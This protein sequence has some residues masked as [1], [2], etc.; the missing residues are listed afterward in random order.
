MYIYNERRSLQAAFFLIMKRRAEARLFMHV[1]NAL[2]LRKAGFVHAANRAGPVVGK[3][4]ECGTGGDAVV[5]IADLGI[6]RVT[7]H[8]AS[9]FFHILYYLVVLPPPSPPK[10]GGQGGWDYYFSGQ[11]AFMLQIRSTTLLE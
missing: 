6:V 10:G 7:A 9:V 2:F 4:L 3:I 1:Y 8:V 11:V 5:R